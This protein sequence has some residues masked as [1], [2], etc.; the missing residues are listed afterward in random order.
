MHSLA[1]QQDEIKTYCKEHGWNLLH[2]FCDEG[3][4]GAKV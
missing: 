3:I 2:V 4:S 1:Y